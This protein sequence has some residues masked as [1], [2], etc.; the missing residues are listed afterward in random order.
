M[1]CFQEKIENKSSKKLFKSQEIVWK[2]RVNFLPTWYNKQTW[3]QYGKAE[4]SAYCIIC[5]NADNHNMVNDIRVENFFIKTGYS[6]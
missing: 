3:L 5:K 1:L 6:N 2:R 4:D